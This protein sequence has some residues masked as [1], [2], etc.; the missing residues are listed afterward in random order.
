MSYKVRI[1]SFE[2]P[3]D[4]LLYLVSRQKVDIGAISITEI[5]DQYLEEV[6]HM[7]RLDLDVASDFLLVASTLLEIKAQSLIPRD[8]TELDDELAELAPSE[9]RDL[10]VERL[11]EY[12]KYKNAAG[13][14]HARLIAEGRMHVRPFGPDASFLGLMPDFLAG[15]SVD[16]L[17][18]LAARAMARREVFL[19]E[20][21][22]IAAKPI[23][24]EVHVRAIHQRIVNRKH[25]RFSDLVSAE[26]PPEV[27]VVTF[28]AILELYKRSMVRL[29]QP[30]TFGDIAIDYIEGSGELNLVGEDALTSVGEE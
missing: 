17:G 24:V 10:L 4:L 6:S 18:L 29:E 1:D 27:V 25:L 26:T 30:E 9:A 21:E 8:R 11:V 13:A 3:F 16:A 7:D 20:S 14:L 19:L 22:H 23:P 5:A 15:V 12:K 28:L 2:G